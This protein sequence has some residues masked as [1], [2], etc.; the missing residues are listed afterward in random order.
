MTQLMP[1]KHSLTILLLTLIAIVS[2]LTIRYIYHFDFT[3]IP[4]L[5]TWHL[6]NKDL[7]VNRPWESLWNLH[8]QPPLFNGLCSLL[9]IWFPKHYEGV[10]E[11]LWFL[12]GYAQTILLYASLYKLS[13]K[14]WLAF[15]ISAYFSITPAFLLYESWYF[16]TYLGMIFLSWS[17]FFLI[18]YLRTEK[19]VWGFALFALLAVI[20]LTISMFHLAWLVLIAIGLIIFSKPQLRRRTFMAALFPVLMV[21]GWYAKNKV[22]FG[23]FTASTWMGMNIARIMLPLDRQLPSSVTN[24]T[25]RRL[26]DIGPFRCLE[27]YGPWLPANDKYKNVPALQE[28]CKASSECNFNNIQYI[29]ISD[30]FQEASIA[31]L[32]SNPKPY[33]SLIKTSTTL[34]FSPAT[35]YFAFKKNRS[36]IID[37]ENFFN[38]GY[39]PIY[40]DYVFL[41]NAIL[42]LAY[43]FS[44]TALVVI[45]LKRFKNVLKGTQKW[46]WQDIAVIYC[47]FNIQY[48]ALAGNL[49]E[50]GEN[51]RFRFQVIPLFLFMLTY[52]YW[53]WKW[54]KKAVTTTETPANT[55]QTAI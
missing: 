35:N 39:I 14:R 25:I 46:Q 20:C 48:L 42:F 7:L 26:A 19:F 31:C 22:M 38:L 36:K 30:K 47:A 11:I 3:A 10:M 6:L 52:L 28:W 32:K 9:I 16:Y 8:S 4:V 50:L 23:H 12:F 2:K 53:H 45:L 33:L 24:D 54:R 27:E 1:R 34:Y 41:T 21:T 43:L 51:M 49:L 15:A 44:F 55:V 5:E 17:L 29:W 13:N 18:Q 40:K 37:Y